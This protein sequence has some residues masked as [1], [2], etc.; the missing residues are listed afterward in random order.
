M[1]KFLKKLFKLIPD[2]SDKRLIVKN[3]TTESM[4]SKKREN[5]QISKNETERIF[6]IARD[7]IGKMED[8]SKGVIQKININKDK[9]FEELEF[10]NKPLIDDKKRGVSKV[11]FTLIFDLTGDEKLYNKFLTIQ[12]NGLPISFIRF[13]KKG[14]CTLLGEH[15]GLSISDLSE[16]KAVFEGEEKDTFYKI[17]ATYAKQL[18]GVDA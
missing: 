9:K 17:E 3:I 5:V 8:D 7:F 6:F 15:I 13:D 2:K 18:V 10:V 14:Q 16:Q 12:K 1:L 4:E 11:I